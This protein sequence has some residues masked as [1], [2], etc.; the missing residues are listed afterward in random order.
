MG[1]H[2]GP[3]GSVEAGQAGSVAT[4]PAALQTRLT[5]LFPGSPGVSF[6]E[7]GTGLRCLPSAAPHHSPGVRAFDWE[8]RQDAGLTTEK[9]MDNLPHRLPLT[10]IPQIILEQ[11]THEHW[12]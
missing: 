6:F 2:S 5:T 7:I 3:A 8:G 4:V 9:Y 10:G 11:R 12:D 1:W